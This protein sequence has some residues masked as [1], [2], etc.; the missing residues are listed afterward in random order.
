[1]PKFII[2]IL[3]PVMSKLT[4]S[5]E[6]VTHKIS[7]SMDHKISYRERM[8]IK[9][10]LMGCKFCERYRDQLLTIQRMLQ[11]LDQS[12]ADEHLTK[13]ARIKIKRSIKDNLPE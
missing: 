2:K 12:H 5:C 3:M 13:E 1:M 4:P 8:Q 7:E 9:I 11:N 10:H 6:V